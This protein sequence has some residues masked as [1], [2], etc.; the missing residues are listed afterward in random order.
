MTTATTKSANLSSTL[1]PLQWNTHRHAAHE[2]HFYSDDAFLLDPLS[3]FVG[4]AL[5][6]GDRVLVIAT[7]EHRAALTSRLGARGPDTA[8]AIRRGHYV[9]L[10]ARETLARIMVDGTPHPARFV[11]VVGGA[12]AAVRDA[13][14][15]DLAD[16]SPDF[17]P[18]GVPHI[19]AF[20]EMVALLWQ[21]GNGEAAMRLEQLWNELA[22]KYSFSLHCAYP[23]HAFQSEADANAFQKICA[24][25]TAVFPDE[26]YSALPSEDQRF[27]N[28]ANLQCRQQM[29]D[30]LL[31][32]KQQLE[33][34]VAARL[35]AEQRLRLSEESLRALSG[36]LL[37]TQDEERR[38]MGRQLHDSVAQNLA[39]IKMNLSLLRFDVR[40]V[41]G[42]VQQ[43]AECVEFADKTITEIR[44][45]SYC[46]YPPMLEEMGLRTALEWFLHE[47]AEQI[48]VLITLNISPGFRRLP[49][50]IE[51]CIFRFVQEALSNVHLHS[52]SGTAQVLL[53]EGYGMVRAEIRDQGR[54]IHPVLLQC[55]H[56]T[57]GMLGIGLRGMDERVRQLGGKLELMSSP[58]GATISATIP[59]PSQ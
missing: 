38:R 44:A 14:R 32:T 57:V 43:I 48:G 55:A 28:V 17:T 49:R 46:L 20:G 16:P 2:V 27:R 3:Q 24:E 26:T 50:D 52:G 47:F 22:E 37:R 13:L 39:A 33:S 36:D 25:H 10:D 29:Y 9:D 53:A 58:T 56:E 12:V 7:P 21:D 51:L 5:E 30:A 8:R 54:G 42:A 34:E 23:M 35:L 6:A 40:Q 4:T 45:I 18:N 11:Q 15:P 1:E 41:S 19:A 59:V 31:Q